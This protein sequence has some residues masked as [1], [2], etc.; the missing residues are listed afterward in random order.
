M[1]NW[2]VQTVRIF[3]RFSI[4]T[5][6]TLNFHIR[7]SPSAYTYSSYTDVWYTNLLTI[8]LCKSIN[9][10]LCTSCKYYRH[11]RFVQGTQEDSHEVL[12]ALLDDIKNEEVE[13]RKSPLV[14]I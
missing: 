4:Q 8:I 6:Q 13:V 3:A 10:C 11:P 2:F 1:V 12:R 5:I 14:Y 9:S 7:F